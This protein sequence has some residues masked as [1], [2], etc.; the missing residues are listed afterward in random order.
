MKLRDENGNLKLIVAIA[1]VAVIIIIGVII[2]CINNKKP[3]ETIAQDPYEYFVMYATNEKVGVIDKKGNEIIK[4]NYIS[5]YIPNQAKDVFICFTDDENYQVLDSKGKDLFTNYSSVYPIVI[6]DTTLEM[7]KN[8][9]SY[10]KDGKYGLIDYSGKELTK[11]IYDSVSSLTNKPGCILVKKDGLYGVVDSKGNTVI[12]TKYNTIKGDE[13]SSETEGYTKTGYIISEKTNTGII[14]GYINYEGKMLIE[15]KYESITRC[16]EYEDDDIY[17]V[18]MNNGKKGVIKNKK[19][20]IKAKYQSIRYYNIAD[21]FVVNRNGKYG[22]YKN[23][24]DE[25]LE[26]I[27]T[28]YSLA[29]NYISVKKDDAMMLYD[30]HGNLINTNN[31]K[32]I[33]ETSNPSYFIATDEANHYSIISKDMQIENNYTNITYAFDNFFI[34][35]TEDGKSGVLNIYSGVEVEPEY[36]YII[37]LENAK[38]LEA[39]KENK[40]DIYSEKFEKVLTMEDAIV[41]KVSD[42][43]FSIYSDTEKQ[44][45]DNTGNLVENTKVYDDLNLY[46]YKADDGKWGFVN[47]QGKIVVDCKYDRV[48]ELNEYGFAGICQDGRWGVIDSSGNVVI[49]PSYEVETYYEPDFIG[50]YLLTESENVFCQELEEVVKSKK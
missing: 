46:S 19:T 47:S 8:V 49:V 50:K 25:I 20:I 22:F 37:V 7:E 43:Y 31:Y 23:N 18:F 30:T 39:R 48:T 41:E 5:I 40:V 9:L 11:P 24:G 3:V 45:V 42:K 21:I 12:D 35:T 33:I 28:E 27:Y 32:S 13:Y 16:L 1:T 14:Y 2:F 29:G 38:A 44:Y 10:E 36:D 4:P 15:P 26:P 6:S 17:L 34:F